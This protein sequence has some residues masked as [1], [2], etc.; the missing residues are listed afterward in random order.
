MTFD[1][2]EFMT[3]ART[4]NPDIDDL[5]ALQLDRMIAAYNKG[6]RTAE[7]LTSALEHPPERI[8]LY[9]HFNTEDVAEVGKQMGLRG[10]R[11]RRFISASDQPLKLNV[12]VEADGAVILEEIDDVV[13]LDWGIVL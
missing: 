6:A 11:L 5:S 8:T 9:A 2:H 3:L 1:L 4:V 10:D 13:S 7:E 12:S